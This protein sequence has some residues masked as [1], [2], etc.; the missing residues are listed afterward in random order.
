VGVS[1]ERG[2][3]LGNDAALRGHIWA[4]RVGAGNIPWRW[5]ANGTTVTNN[6]F[7]PT[8]SMTRMDADLTVATGGTGASAP[9]RTAN[10]VGIEFRVPEAAITATGVFWPWI[11]VTRPDR[12]AGAALSTLYALGGQS[13]YDMA[14]AFTTMPLASLTD[15]FARLTELQT[16]QK[17]AVVWLS[18]GMND[19]GEASKLPAAP[20]VNGYDKSAIK[21]NID[22]ICT[23][24]RSA[25]N[26][27]GVQ[28]VVALIGDYPRG[29]AS[30][31]SEVTAATYRDAM[32]EIAAS[33]PDFV[34]FGDMSQIV[35]FAELVDVGSD[36]F[37]N[38][39][40]GVGATN[41]TSSGWA[42]AHPYLAAGKTARFTG[43]SATFANPAVLTATLAPA[44]VVTPTH[45]RIESGTNVVPGVYP[46]TGTGPNYN[47]PAGAV[48]TGSASGVTGTAID[49]VHLEEDLS[50]QNLAMS[51]VSSGLS[52]AYAQTA[53]QTPPRIRQGR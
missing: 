19:S 43:A 32:R 12:T 5:L 47:L 30:E 27:A 23:T 3:P 49:C 18:T 11:R 44:G 17:I 8:T 7:A 39:I 10:T 21:Y 51:L 29:A 28:L 1:I 20:G 26:A 4:S 35:T 9:G 22:L 53:R 46:S 2:S 6:N 38:V 15:Y 25:A 48:V 45:I 52:E 34:C 13:S 24:L 36:A 33:R 14:L 31:A 50:F 42:R 16:G 41:G 40:Y 37:R